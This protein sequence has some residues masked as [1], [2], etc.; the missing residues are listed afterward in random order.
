MKIQ[1][2]SPTSVAAEINRLHAEAGRLCAESSTAL[3]A[4][5]V[6]AWE[7]G[8]L[9][10]EEKR[11]VRERMG[12]GAWGLWLAQNFQGSERTAQRYMLLAKRVPD[13]SVLAGIGLRQAYVQLGISTQDKSRGEG[14]VTPPLPRHV[15]LANRL[16]GALAARGNR[17]AWTPQKRS[18]YQRDLRALYERLRVLFETPN[19]AGSSACLSSPRGEGT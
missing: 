16:L 2:N 12:P 5:L 15:S 17:S 18:A 3:H 10:V 8:R 1:T 14:I 19:R 13:V 6:A 7:A 9:L 11:R 4:A